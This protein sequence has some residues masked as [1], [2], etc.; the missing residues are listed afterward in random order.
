[1]GHIDVPLGYTFEERKQM[2][3]PWGF[4]CR[5]AMCAAGP[6]EKALSDN[7]RERLFD[8]HATLSQVAK[9]TSEAIGR[10]RVDVLVREATVLIAEEQLDPLI[11]YDHVF[12]K[13]YIAVNELKKARRYI[14]RAE[15]KWKLYEGEDSSD[16]E[17]LGQLRHELR[18][19][20][21]EFDDEDEDD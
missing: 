3:K 19:L 17:E 1:M 15:A 14:E 2:L 20:E 21:E 12:A 4:Q 10:E 11:A 16:A 7:R 18:E 6:N 9:G 13:A 8:L 5:C